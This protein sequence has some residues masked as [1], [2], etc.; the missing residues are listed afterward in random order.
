MQQIN[1]K[2]LGI[3]QY[4]E[5]KHMTDAEF[6]LWI[7]LSALETIAPPAAP[8]M[9]FWQF[10]LHFIYKQHLQLKTSKIKVISE[11]M[12]SKAMD[13]SEGKFASGAIRMDIGQWVMGNHCKR[14][15]RV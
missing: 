12:Q 2:I 8:Q 14:N 11:P 9:H 3:N 13:K 7:N 6:E 4:N 5:C 15:Q 10:W 1:H